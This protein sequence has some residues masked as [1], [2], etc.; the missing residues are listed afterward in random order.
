[1]DAIFMSS[2]SPEKSFSPCK[3]LKNITKRNGTGANF[4]SKPS[5]NLAPTNIIHGGGLLFASP[6]S[7]SFSYHSSASLLNP[8]FY[9]NHHQLQRQP[10]PPLLPPPISNKPLHSSLPSR[11]RSLSSSPS[12]RKN[13][14]TRS[15]Q[16][17]TPKRSKSKQFTV[18]GEDQPKNDNLK[19]TEATKT[20]AISKS[21]IMASA[22]PLGPD[23]NDLPKVL[24]SSY[25]T[26]GSVKKDCEKVSGS[27]FTL[28]PPPSSLPLPKFSLRPKLS[29][30]AEAAGIDAGATDNL[31][32]LLR[33]R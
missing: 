23:P 29:C 18:K 9:Q 14:R 13:N 7:F 28:S 11:T 16:S 6:P 1:M 27:I 31:R 17:I 2:S 22:K 25:L 32:R 24:A 10:Q 12:N 30:N 8:I 33:L 5:E 21:F 4:V 20:Q 3:Q 15:D 19:P 26:T